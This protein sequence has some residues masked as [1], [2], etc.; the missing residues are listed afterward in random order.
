M[1]QFI[2]F[3]HVHVHV[4]KGPHSRLLFAHVFVQLVYSFETIIL[5][6]SQHNNI[7]I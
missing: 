6:G 4:F 3:L 2:S 7:V 1:G 5:L